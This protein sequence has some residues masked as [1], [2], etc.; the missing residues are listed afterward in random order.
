ME[1]FCVLFLLA[2]I[3]KLYLFKIK[4][5]SQSPNYKN[6]NFIQLQLLF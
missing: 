2:K 4:I 6:I 5:I 1:C 3:K